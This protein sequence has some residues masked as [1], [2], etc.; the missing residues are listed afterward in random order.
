MVDN[1][2]SSE[3]AVAAHT[4]FGS[5]AVV[6][7]NLDSVRIRDAAGNRLVEG[8]FVV[9]GGLDCSPDCIHLLHLHSIHHLTWRCSCA[10]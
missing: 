4:H 6:R 2:H 8:S 10:I 1:R 3:A 7:R 5:L 9:P